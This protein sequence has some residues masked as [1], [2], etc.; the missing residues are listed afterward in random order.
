M[1][2]EKD[3]F[4]EDLA[5]LQEILSQAERWVTKAENNENI[6]NLNHSCKTLEENSSKLLKGLYNQIINNH[7]SWDETT[8]KKRK[9]EYDNIVNQYKSILQRIEDIHS[10]RKFTP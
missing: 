3:S 2:F 4:T 9:G 8:L 6:K 1:F 5:K 10:E 7:T